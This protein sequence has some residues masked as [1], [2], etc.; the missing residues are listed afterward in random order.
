MTTTSI[1][2]LEKVLKVAIFESQ[3]RH[4]KP[5][6]AVI[7]LTNDQ[8]KPAI[9]DLDIIYQR[10]VN[11]LTDNKITKSTLL[12]LHSRFKN[13]GRM[14]ATKRLFGKLLYSVFLVPSTN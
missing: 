8:V 1:N 11:N 6:F 10:K 9:R 4:G 3:K 14:G 12:I 2:Q 5:L 7:G 13:R